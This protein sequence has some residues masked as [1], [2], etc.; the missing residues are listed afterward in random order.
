M[1]EEKRAMLAESLRAWQKANPDAHKAAV[2]AWAKT[3]S[4]KRQASCVKRRTQKLN[5]TPKWA[6]SFFIEEAYDL[7]AKRSKATGFQWHVDHIVP[8]VSKKV[9]GLH[10]EL[11]LRV[12]PGVENISKGNRY[13]PDMP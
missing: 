11:N 3:F 9:C 10:C 2:T 6:N 5:A 8:L 13:W 4:H 1:P 7:A 12:I